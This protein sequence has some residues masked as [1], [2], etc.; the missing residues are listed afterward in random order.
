LIKSLL[1]EVSRLVFHYKYLNIKLYS[2]SKIPIKLRH[3]YSLVLMIKVLIYSLVILIFQLVLKF[4]VYIWKE[5]YDIV[6]SNSNK[7]NDTNLLAS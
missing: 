5:N 3:R 2:I 4:L 7:T 1:S 6:V